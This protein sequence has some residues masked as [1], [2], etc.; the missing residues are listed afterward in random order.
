MFLSNCGYFHRE[1][2]G[3]DI[4]FVRDGN[5]VDRYMIGA[6]SQ[7][8]TNGRMLLSSPGQAPMLVHRPADVVQ[9]DNTASEQHGKEHIPRPPNA[10]IL[11]RKER[12]HA[13]AAANPG[14]HNNHTCEFHI[15]LSSV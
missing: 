5:H 14:I 12:H 11:Y 3:S 13:V 7:F 1:H 4:I 8:I 10:Y 9:V 6:L 2:V 15:S